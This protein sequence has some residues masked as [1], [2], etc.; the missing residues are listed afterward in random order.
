M[1]DLCLI[2]VNDWSC[3]PSMEILTGLFLKFLVLC[4]LRVLRHVTTESDGTVYHLNLSE[5][6]EK[7]QTWVKF[8]YSQEC[9]EFTCIILLLID[10]AV[11]YWSERRVSPCYSLTSHDSRTLNHFCINKNRLKKYSKT[12]YFGLFP[13]SSKYNH[14]VLQLIISIDFTLIL[15]RHTMTVR[16][17]NFTCFIAIFL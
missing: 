16:H 17:F 1:G 5:P 15:N 8:L 14:N 12:R 4:D 6:E 2:R 7:F 3:L 11:I 13:K 10:R 9:V